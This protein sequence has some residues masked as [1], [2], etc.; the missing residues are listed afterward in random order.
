MDFKKKLNI[1]ISS[2][3]YIISKYNINK[4]FFRKNK[5]PIYIINNKPLYLKV[6]NQ[7]YE[8]GISKVKLSDF[9]SKEDIQLLLNEVK[10]LSKQNGLK[11]E[12]QYLKN[13]LG[14]DYLTKKK[15]IFKPN[16]PILKIGL[17]PFIL[18]VVNSYLNEKSNLTSLK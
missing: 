15:L 14:G 10:V 7:L 13:Y 16:N 5:L 3:R 4:L 1:Y 11:F 8:D 2:F 12:K 6:I 9:I 18:S 17:N